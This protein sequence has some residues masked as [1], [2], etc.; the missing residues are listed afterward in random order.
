MSYDNWKMTEPYDIEDDYRNHIEDDVPAEL[1]IVKLSGRD[2]NAFAIM[3]ACQKAAR[4]AGWSAE[5]IKLVMSNM[6]AGD[7]DH[8]LQ[9]AMKH[10]DVQ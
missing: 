8:L 5:K 2:G 10:F 7:Y 6:M 9:T 4:K 3:G 1:P